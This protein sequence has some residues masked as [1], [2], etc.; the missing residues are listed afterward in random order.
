MIVKTQCHLVPAETKAH[1]IVVQ[2]DMGNSLFAAVHMA[3][4][5]IFSSIGEKDFAAVLRLVGEKPPQIIEM[6]PRQL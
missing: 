4:G 1:S 2:D 5:V 3:E 6:P